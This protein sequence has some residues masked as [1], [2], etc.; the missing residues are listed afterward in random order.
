M[1]LLR[2]RVLLRAVLRG[3][4]PGQ[5]QRL[6]RPGHPGRHRHGPGPAGRPVARGPRRCRRGG[7]R[8]V[9]GGAGGAQEV[10]QGPADRRH[11]A[12][13]RAVHGL[14]RRGRRRG[15][16]CGLRGGGRV[17]RRRRRPAPAGRG[18]RHGRHAA[19]LPRPAGRPLAARP[20]RARPR[21]VRRLLVVRRTLAP[22]VTRV[23]GERNAI[24]A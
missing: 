5:R 13:G 3:G 15:A 16:R 12:R 10:P 9:D 17:R 2:L 22:A 4:P 7:G 21:R 24:T 11:V 18:E 19:R 1:R 23:E 6:L 14:L 8:C 20:H